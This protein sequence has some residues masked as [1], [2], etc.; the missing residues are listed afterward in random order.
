[1]QNP[2][3]FSNGHTAS[4]AISPDRRC[5]DSTNVTPDRNH[6]EIDRGLSVRSLTRSMLHKSWFVCPA[7]GAAVSIGARVPSGVP[8]Q[9]AFSARWPPHRRRHRFKVR[10]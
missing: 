8:T 10:R 6:G 3:R 5:C 7:T 2:G 9:G 1:M 4:P